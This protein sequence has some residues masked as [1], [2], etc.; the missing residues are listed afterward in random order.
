MAE[1]VKDKTRANFCDYLEPRPDAWQ[2]EGQDS[3]AEAERR[4]EEMF[5]GSGAP[6]AGSGSAKGPSDLESL[7]GE[8]KESR[9]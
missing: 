4:L 3:T 1:E 2:P 6:D 8:M 7:F 9:D 5:G